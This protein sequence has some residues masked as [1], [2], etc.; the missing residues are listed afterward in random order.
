M[1][2]KRFFSYLVLTLMIGVFAFAFAIGQTMAADGPQLAQATVLEGGDCYDVNA[3]SDPV[4]Y[5]QLTGITP[6]NSLTNQDFEASFNAYDSEGADDFVVD[7][8]GWYITGMDLCGVYS[9]SNG[10]GPVNAVN[11]LFYDDNAGEPAAAPRCDYTG[12][13]QT[14]GGTAGPL[15]SPAPMEID[16]DGTPC[17]LEPGTYWAVISISQTFGSAGQ[18]FTSTGPGGNGLWRNPGNGF[19]TGCTDWATPASCGIGTGESAWMFALEGTGAQPTD[20]NL[21]SFDGGSNNSV[22]AAL[23]I[24]L[25]SLGVAALVTVR[26]RL[27]QNQVN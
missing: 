7:G 9:A 8:Q 3:D 25:F 21:S 14:T 16:W 4:L 15:G 20:V 6:P 23:I 13:V 1:Q 18:Y 17:A 26:Y 12:T 19:G 27:S 5:D 24:G 2:K 22:V 10:T 11:V